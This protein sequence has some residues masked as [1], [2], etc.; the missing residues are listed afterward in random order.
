[1]KGDRQKCIQAG[2][3]DYVSKPVDIEHLVS[4][5]ALCHHARQQDASQQRIAALQCE[6][7]LQKADAIAL[8]R[9]LPALGRL[10]GLVDEV[11]RDLEQ[12]SSSLI[13]GVEPQ[14][15]AHPWQADARPETQP[16]PLN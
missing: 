9:G 10:R 13:A 14:P 5:V 1:M 12:G 15:F 4:V 6:L 7:L 16:R 8:L 3:S 11:G 2:A